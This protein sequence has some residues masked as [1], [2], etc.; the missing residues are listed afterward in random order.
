MLYLSSL[1]LLSKQRAF[2][3]LFFSPLMF[4]HSY[5]RQ[6]HR[7]YLPVCLVIF[8]RVTTLTFEYE[9]VHTNYSPII[10]H[11]SYLFSIRPHYNHYNIGEVIATD[12]CSIAALIVLRE[13]EKTNELD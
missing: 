11:L 1:F 5:S 9:D 8:T 12:N 13:R 3:F 7:I 6:M 10:G 2:F 4:I